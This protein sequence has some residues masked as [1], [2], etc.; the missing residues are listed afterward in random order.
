MQ[1]LNLKGTIEGRGEPAERNIKTLKSVAADGDVLASP[2]G[3]QAYERLQ[4]R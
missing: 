1:V 3:R 4:Q 2:A